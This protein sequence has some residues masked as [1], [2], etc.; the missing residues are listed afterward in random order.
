MKARRDSVSISQG[1]IRG[2][3]A[4]HL[5]SFMPEMLGA[6]WAGRLAASGSPIDFVVFDGLHRGIIERIV[7]VEKRGED[8]MKAEQAAILAAVDAGVVGLESVVLAYATVPV[9][10]PAHCSTPT[11]PLAASL[12]RSLDQR[13]SG[14]ARAPP[15]H[16]PG[17]QNS[18]GRGGSV[19]TRRR[20]H[21]RKSA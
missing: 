4:Q 6:L 14:S 3:A 1:V 19:F 11:T 8:S 20:Q 21:A 5:A 10:N 18:T 12:A 2:D 7:L 15:P 13:G 17:G 16:D 9:R